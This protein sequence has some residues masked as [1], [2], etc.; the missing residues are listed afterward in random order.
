MKEDVLLFQEISANAWPALNFIFLNGWVVRLGDGYTRRANSV[1]PINYTG[2]NVES[3]ILTVEELYSL[4]NLPVVFQ[5]PDY[6]APTNLKKLL[7]ERDYVEFDESLLMAEEIP[8][9]SPIE[10]NESFSYEIETGSSEEWFSEFQKLTNRSDEAKLKNQKIIDRIP[11]QKAFL[12]A[13]DGQKVVGLCLGV[14]EREYI[15]IYD[16]IVSSDHR[17]LGIGQSILAHLIEW[18][19][20]NGATT[21]YLQVQGDNSGAISLYKKIGLKDKYHYRYL[22]KYSKNKKEK[23]SNFC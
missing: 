23:A 11:F 21:C 8:K 12:I 10:I 19:K 5:I 7:L 6:S 1:M 15:G 22:I 18:G 13:R 3:D 9:L 2:E 4:F 16:M 14:L 17:R 20:K